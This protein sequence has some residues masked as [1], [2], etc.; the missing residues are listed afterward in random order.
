M[1]CRFS[2][3]ESSADLKQA[4]L[5]DIIY[6]HIYPNKRVWSVYHMNKTGEET[7]FFDFRDFKKKI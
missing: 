3:Q 4:A 1:H 6:N 5:L 7:D 2:F